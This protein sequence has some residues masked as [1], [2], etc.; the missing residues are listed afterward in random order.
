MLR[1][2]TKL[3]EQVELYISESYDLGKQ[4]WPDKIADFMLQF[5]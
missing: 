5:D 2:L 3:S 1:E 4:E